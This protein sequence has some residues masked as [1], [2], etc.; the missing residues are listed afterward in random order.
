MREACSHPQHA[1]VSPSD[2]LRG[3]RQVRSAG[4][5]TARLRGLGLSEA[6][7]TRPQHPRGLLCGPPREP[8]GYVCAG[9]CLSPH[10]AGSGWGVLC[11]SLCTP[12]PCTGGEPGGCSV[13][14]HDPLGRQELQWCPPFVQKHTPCFPFLLSLF[15][16][17]GFFP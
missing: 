9:I 5:G 7:P 1:E 4:T 13:R 15:L 12:C 8:Q 2:G 16:Y 6:L 14:L 10:G 17:T 3:R 11:D